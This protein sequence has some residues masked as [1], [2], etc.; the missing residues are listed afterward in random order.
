MHDN[1]VSMFAHTCP[2]EICSHIEG[3]FCNPRTISF[4]GFASSRKVYHTPSFPHLSPVSIPQSGGSTVTSPESRAG[5]LLVRSV[6]RGAEE[7]M[8]SSEQH[9]CFGIGGKKSNRLSHSGSC[10]LGLRPEPRQSPPCGRTV[11]PRALFKLDAAQG[12]PVHI[13]CGQLGSLR[14][15]DQDIFLFFEN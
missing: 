12:G 13:T 7:V 11:D 14:Q 15:R 4:D 1:L 10:G 8:G 5:F 2:Y 6:E 3:R 9:V